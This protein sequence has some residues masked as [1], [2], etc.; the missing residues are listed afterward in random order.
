MPSLAA[1]HVPSTLRPSPAWL[2]VLLGGCR[3]EEPPPTFERVPDAELETVPATTFGCAPVA[4]TSPQALEGDRVQLQFVCTG[5]VPAQRWELGDGPPGATIDAVSGVISWQTD[6][7]SAGT[8][9]MVVNAISGETREPGTGAVFIND[10]WGADGNQPIDPATYS[11]EF[12]LPVVSFDEPEG[13]NNSVSVATPFRY[14]G[15]LYD[16][17][18]QLRG[19][20]SSHYPKHSWRLDFPKEDEFNSVVEGFPKRRYLALTTLFDDNAY[21]RQKLCYDAW[22]SLSTNYPAVNSEFVVVYRNGE[23]WGLYMLTDHIDDEWWGDNGY[24]EAGNLY[25]GTSHAANFF[26]N[27]LGEPKASWHDGYEKKE[28]DPEDWAD[29]DAFVQFVVE[30]D[31]DT[32][33]TSISEHVTLQEAEDWWVLTLALAAYD[34][35]DKNAYFHRDP[36][37]EAFHLVVWDFNDSLGQD[38]K[39]GRS[40][41]DDDWDFT[42]SNG[43]FARLLASDVHGPELRERL[44]SSLAGPLSPDALNPLID[45]YMAAIGPSM[46]RDWAAWG[47]TYRSYESWSNREDFTEPEEEVAYIRQWIQERHDWV[48]E[49][50]P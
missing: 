16:G 15:H 42:D 2:V 9:T 29:L 24:D 17:A 48:V 20:T 14:A 38:W 46:E 47:D 32:F 3:Y 31:D 26:D 13:L 41:A 5:D 8:W 49:W 19:A 6:L 45:D 50:G 22:N 23:Y 10:A 34:S 21:F 37:A 28:G 35:I 30:S 44:S 12:G 1:L 18:I 33:D 43:L 36:E 4:T 40:P 39:T 7:T 25:K 11:H 27:Y